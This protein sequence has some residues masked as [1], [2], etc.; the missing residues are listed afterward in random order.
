MLHSVTS[1][2]H[3]LRPYVT[4]DPSQDSPEPVASARSPCA[5]SWHTPQAHAQC[6]RWL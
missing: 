3:G 6:V 1:E 4:L 2:W 5:V